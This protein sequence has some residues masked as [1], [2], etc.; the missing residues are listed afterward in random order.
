MAC[1]GPDN[2]DDDN[3]QEQ[4]EPDNSNDEITNEL[5]RQ[6]EA[7]EIAA[8]NEVPGDDDQAVGDDYD[9]LTSGELEEA[10]SSTGGYKCLQDLEN[11]IETSSSFEDLASTAAIEIVP[12][13]GKLE[14]VYQTRSTTT[15]RGIDHQKKVYDSQSDSK[16]M[17]KV[18]QSPAIPLQPVAKASSDSQLSQKPVETLQTIKKN[19]PGP[20]TVSNVAS[21]SKGQ[22]GKDASQ[23]K[24]QT[25]KDVSQG[26]GQ[27]GKDASQG[28]G[29]TGK[30]VSQGKG[31]TG[32]DTSQG[33]GQSGKDSKG[34]V[35]SKTSSQPSSSKGATAPKEEKKSNEKSKHY[36]HMCCAI[37]LFLF[38]NS[39]Q[40]NEKETPLEG[41]KNS[42]N[43]RSSLEWVTCL[44]E[45]SYE[46]KALHWSYFCMLT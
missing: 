40:P 22:T 4:E 37:F 14:P 44:D 45:Y 18:D 16:K 12:V 19:M 46:I 36:H 26:K 33:K 39:L 2:S 5:C 43:K 23:G 11:V 34:G 20:S 1:A 10:L 35:K 7:G 28:K 8:Y 24:G 13:G 6:R 29:Q 30:D 27:T 38:L 3:Y 9:L 41:K 21:Q 32:K 15:A 17:G 42:I 31:Q 25:G